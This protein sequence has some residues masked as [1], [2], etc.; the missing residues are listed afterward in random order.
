M[1]EPFIAVHNSLLEDELFVECQTFAIKKFQNEKKNMRTNY[2]CWEEGILKDS[3]VVYIYDLFQTNILYEKIVETI[4]NKLKIDN[5]KC[6]MFYYWTQ[7]SHIPWHN[8]ETHTGGITIYLNNIW[9]SDWGGIFL[10]ET[11]NSING[12]YPSRNVCVQQNGKVRHAVCPT[13]NRSE[14]RYTIQIFY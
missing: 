5:V 8:D 7:N 1:S 11:N 13:T 9:D 6:I 14:I 4:K 12:I 3:S 2:R 10:F